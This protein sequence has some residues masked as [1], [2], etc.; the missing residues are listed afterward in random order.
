M[1]K[2][3][4]WLGNEGNL[5]I[6]NIYYFGCDFLGS[7]SYLYCNML[8]HFKAS[9]VVSSGFPRVWFVNLNIGIIKPGKSILMFDLIKQGIQER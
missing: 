6:Q 7:C 2:D 4:G 8:K 5:W 1:N 3:L 9:A